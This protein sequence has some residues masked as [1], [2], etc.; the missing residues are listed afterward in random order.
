[1]SKKLAIIGA[2]YLQLPLVK[3]AKEM[4]IQTHVFA[5]EEGAVAKDMADFFYP[6]S[7]L[8][9]YKILQECRA[10]RPDGIVSIASDIA[11]P[12]VNFIAAQLNLTGNSMESTVVSTD[13]FEMRKR[14]SSRNIPCPRFILLEKKGRLDPDRFKGLKFPLII[15]PTD[16]SGSRGVTKV[17]DPNHLAEAVDRAFSES[18]ANRVIVEEYIETKKEVSV[19]M[20][21]WKG[22]HHFLAITDKLTTGEPYF[23][24]VQQHEP[25]DLPAELEYRIK[26]I[27]KEAL[28]ALGIQYG[29]SHSEI[30]I[31]VEGNPV[32]VEVGARM[33]GDN[34][35]ASL[36]ELSTGYDFLMGVIEVSMGIEPEIKKTFSQYAGIYYLTPN[37]GIVNDVVVNTNRHPE[38]TKWEVFIRP[39]DRID[40]PVKESAARS[41]YFMY[42]SQSLFHIEDVSKVIDIK[43]S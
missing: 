33:G 15:K 41:G 35:G 29:A 9:K 25:A 21:S 12:T 24:E 34:I 23:V 28:S 4:G 3:K 17:N 13:K 27:V 2:S 36:V 16:R 11:M 8:E 22:E 38:I 1:M 7:I 39:G 32:I 5:W 43:V 40:F 20:I 10:I 26:Q 19:E 37:S 18:L 31:D 42:Q 6:V 14:L 30:I